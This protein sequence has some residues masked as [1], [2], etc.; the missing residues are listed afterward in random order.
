MRRTTLTL[1]CLLCAATVLGVH[2]LGHSRARVVQVITLGRL[3]DALVLAPE[4]DRAFVADDAAGTVTVLDLAVGHLLRTVAVGPPGRF[5]P[6]ALTLDPRT[7]HLFVADPTDSLVPSRVQMLDSRSGA[8]LASVP[9]GREANALAVDA[10]HAQVLVAND[11][12]GTLSLLDARTG[13]LRRTVPLGLLPL[14]LAVDEHTARAFVIGPATP[15][16]L[17]LPSPGEGAW[18]ELL[19]VLDTRSGALIRRTPLGLGSSPLAVDPSSGRVF[20]ACTDDDSVRV[21]DARSGAPLRTVTLGV[22]PS[23]LAVDERRRR[24]YVV[25]AAAGTLSLLDA[26]TGALLATRRVDPFAR[27]AYP[28]PEALAVDAARDRVYLSTYGPTD[29]GPNGLTLRGNGTL[30]VLDATTGAVLRKITVGV[31]PQAVAV[32][33]HS[34]RVVVL[35]GGGMVTQTPEGWGA[36]WLGRLRAWLPWW[37]HVARPAS[38]ITQAPG[39]VSVIDGAP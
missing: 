27:A 1:L 12:D 17:T 38:S 31:A 4:G 28:L 26:R 3:P 5:A 25:S 29:H 8:R 34:G 39:S 14:A 16:A 18:V 10:R 9:V 13:R 30:Y 37:G 22:A 20:V 23:A 33:K 19:G 35:N 2:D 32:D 7:H 6:L 15:G 21:L 36:P 11:T 24:V